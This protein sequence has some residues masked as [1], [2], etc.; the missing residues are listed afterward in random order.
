[1]R[2]ALER[3]NLIEAIKL[4]RSSGIDLKQA[5]EAIET[6]ISGKPAAPHAPIFAPPVMG[7]PLPGV[8]VEALKRGQKIEAIRLM[9]EQTG[10]GLKEAKD[11]VDGYEVAHR[12]PLS[13]LSP[14]QVS[15]TG[16]GIWWVVALVLACLVAYLVFRRMG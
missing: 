16:S 11:A 2:E 14:G 13:G 9:R 7:Q 3:G 6:H 10:L 1:V 4:L 5:K 8:V 12:D 15:E